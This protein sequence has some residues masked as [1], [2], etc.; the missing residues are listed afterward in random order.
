VARQY[1][2]VV[3][4]A[5]PGELAS[6][7]AAMWPVIQHALREMEGLD[8]IQYGSVLLLDPTSP[9]RLP[10]DIRQ[11]AAMLGEDQQADG[12]IAV[13]E[14]E[15]NPY[16]HCVVDSGNGYMRDLIPGAGKYARRQDLP[17]VY[18]INGLLYLWRRAHVLESTNWRAGRLRMHI[19]PESRALH[20]DDVAQFEHAARLLETG[21]LRLPWLK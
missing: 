7:T 8:Q 11:A 3:P 1:G 14:P 5:R 9:T 15:F 13:S 12:V 21:A 16:W 4:F 19:V 18:R 17:T 20:I 6:D 2:G 10:E